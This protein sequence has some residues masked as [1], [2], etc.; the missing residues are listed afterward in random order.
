PY[1]PPAPIRLDRGRGTARVI[2]RLPVGVVPQPPPRGREP[3]RHTSRV[4]LGV[5]PAG[6]APARGHHRIVRGRWCPAL[7]DGPSISRVDARGGGAVRGEPVRPGAV[8]GAVSLRVPGEG[9]G[10]L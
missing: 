5:P 3:R 9:V 8:G 10:V 7:R 2:P 6:V 1:S 4:P